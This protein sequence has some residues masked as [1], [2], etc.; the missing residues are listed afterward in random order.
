M[1]QEKSIE[2]NEVLEEPLNYPSAKLG[3][4]T[5]KMNEIKTLINLEPPIDFK[6]ISKH[7]VVYGE[8]LDNLYEACNIELE[9]KP[10]C[11]TKTRTG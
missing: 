7:I 11:T 9:K 10:D 1:S 5:R 3:S 8:R 6:I 4:V 2:L